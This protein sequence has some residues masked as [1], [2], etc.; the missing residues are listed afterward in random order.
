MSALT[1]AYNDN[2]DGCEGNNKI[3]DTVCDE[4]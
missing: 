2:D 3:V 4:W 1:D